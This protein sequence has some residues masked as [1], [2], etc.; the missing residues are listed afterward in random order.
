MN[1]LVLVGVAV[2]AFPLA[3]LAMHAGGGLPV[4]AQWFVVLANSLLWGVVA[5][6]AAWGLGR[7]QRGA[8]W[9]WIA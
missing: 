1:R 2:A 9:L 8:P 4:P 7:A 3:S 5:A 6:G